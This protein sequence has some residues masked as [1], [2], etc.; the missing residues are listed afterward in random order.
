MSVNYA[1]LA[2]PE[3][4]GCQGSLWPPMDF[5][6]AFTLWRDLGFDYEGRHLNLPAATAVHVA[7]R[8]G[9]LMVGLYVG[10]LSLHL[11][12]VGFQDNVCRYGLLLLTVLLF[13]LAIGVMEVVAHLPLAAA[14]AHT[15]VGAL[16]LL[17]VVTVYHV[18][19]APPRAG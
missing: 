4:P 6:E 5:V 12:R 18:N 10:W 1:A 14:V 16:L 15:A 2:C 11:L 19:R 9:A 3:F 13:Q 17:A 8:A 7:H